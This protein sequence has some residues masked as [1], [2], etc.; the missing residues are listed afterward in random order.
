MKMKFFMLPLV[1]AIL[2]STSCK[3]SSEEISTP[4]N[5]D[6]EQL[7]VQQDKVAH[8]NFNGNLNDSSGNHLNPTYVNN[9]TYTTDRFG[10]AADAIVFGGP[11]NFSSL[12]LPSP[13]SKVPGV[14]FAISVWFKA[15]DISRSQTLIKADGGEYNVY[16]GY[17]LQLGA[18]G[19]GTLSFNIGNNNGVTNSSGRNSI[20]T[21]AVIIANTWYHVV[22]NVRGANDMDVYING[23]K[24]NNCTYSGTASSMVFCTQSNQQIGVLGFF[25][26]SNNSEYEGLMDD[27]RIYKKIL[28]AQEVAGL[29]NFHP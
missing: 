28:S 21:P 17:W 12:T 15:A 14:P 10:R 29:Y 16:S 27:Y 11:N 9:I 25:M 22:I 18:G 8:Y 4:V 24:N 3:K 19:T 20:T 7:G 13:A 26:G 1:A 5:N 6:P 23:V 2:V